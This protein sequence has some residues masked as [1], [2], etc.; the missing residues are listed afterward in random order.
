[1]GQANSRIA[2]LDFT[3]GVLV[4]L[5]VV[6][7]VLNYLDYGAIPHTYLGFVPASFLVI[8]GFLV[9]QVYAARAR[10]DFKNAAQRLAIRAAKLLLIFTVL[11]VGA[12]LVWSRNRY[13]TELNVAAFF[14]D[15]VGVYLTGDAP[16][17]A[18]D[19]LVPIGYT[20]VV[21]IWLLKVG[22]SKRVVVNLLAWGL[23]LACAVLE[24]RGFSVNTLNF[25]AAGMLGV[26]LGASRV[27]ALERFATSAPV[28]ALVG[29]AYVGILLLGMDSYL[30]Q[31]FTTVAWLAIFFWM[32]RV[33]ASDQWWFE[34]ICLLGRYSLI[35]YIV[36]ILY[37]QGTKGL[38][39]MAPQQG[40]VTV[41]LLTLV[42]SLATWGTI[43]AVE[44]ARRRSRLIDRAYR[45]AFA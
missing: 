25:M 33:L 15:W 42:I 21:S 30:V 4:V 3:K 7:H 10:T 11:N 31:I 12:R 23:V 26:S 20:L 40:L 16:G 8:T 1:M 36:Q 18:F 45:V 27:E 13:G 37:L 14:R 22:A 6:Y 34:Q 9:S 38:I 17:V 44:E 35:G 5:M 32:G 41:A 43:F 29:S 24:M 2:A 19:V 39:L 28:V